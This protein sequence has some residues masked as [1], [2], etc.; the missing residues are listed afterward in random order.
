M[1]DLET[2][3]AKGELAPVY[4]LS[5]EELLVSRV[6]ARLKAALVTPVT[7]AFNCD[8]LE[9]KQSSATAILNAARTLP[10]MG[11][12]RLV[13]VRD[14][15]AL[16]ADG[17]GALVPYLADPAPSTVLV[18]IAHKVD[19][20]LK[21][22]QAAKKAGFHHVLEAPRQLAPWLV[23]EAKRRDAQLLPDA[24]RRLVEVAGKDLG[25]LASALDSLSLYAGE[26]AIGPDDVDSL[27]A[28][29]SERNVF[30]LCDAV[31]E[32]NRR[33]ALVAVAKLMEQKESSVGV[34]I[35]LARHFRQ[36]FLAREL[37]ERR[38]G[39]LARALG[40]PPFAV[41]KLVAHGKRVSAQALPRAYRMLA[42]A[43]RDLKGSAKSALGER[44]ILERLVSGLADLSSAKRP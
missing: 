7:Q 31:S 33:R 8:V 39:D 44:I 6:A 26:R 1:A 24:A 13:V 20:R 30:E 37:T 5:G 22:F 42:R 27:I 40:V 34:A 14:V 12:T 2:A 32:G 15:E 29:T 41:D 18:L 19:G 38:E 4:V 16:A 23:A 25:R 21:F 10:M 28:D 35:M 3:I 36:V 9:A 43:D 11:K 17:L